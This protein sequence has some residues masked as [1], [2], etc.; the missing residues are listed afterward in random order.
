MRG[1]TRALGGDGTTLVD[2]GVRASPVPAA[3]DAITRARTR[4]PMSAAR[5]L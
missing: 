3:L 5:S 2:A 1:A 4:V